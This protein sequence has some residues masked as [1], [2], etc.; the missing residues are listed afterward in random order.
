MGEIED[1]KSR[2]NQAQATLNNYGNL[3]KEKKAVEERCGN[4]IKQNEELKYIVSKLENDINAYRK[5]ESQLKDLER[6]NNNL[7]KEIE[8]LNN[9]LKNQAGELNDFRIRYFSHHSDT[10]RSRARLESTRILS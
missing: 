5:A 8:R 4:Q 6:N 10:V 2:Y 3:E 9:L 7:T 1:W